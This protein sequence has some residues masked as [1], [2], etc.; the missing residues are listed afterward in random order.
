MFTNGHHVIQLV[1]R[2]KKKGKEDKFLDFRLL[3]KIREVNKLK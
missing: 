3:F 1:K 2:K